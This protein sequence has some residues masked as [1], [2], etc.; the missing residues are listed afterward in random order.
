VVQA[1]TK[2][3]EKELSRMFADKERQLQETQM[4]VAK[5]LGEAEH[6]VSTLQSGRRS[7]ERRRVLK[8]RA[9]NLH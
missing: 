1:K 4:I 5:K 6:R 3:K 7:W 2:E 9:K 8:F